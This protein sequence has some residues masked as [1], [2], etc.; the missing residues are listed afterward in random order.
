MEVK[1]LGRLMLDRRTTYPEQG[2]ATRAQTV[3]ERKPE[4][5]DPVWMYPAG[6]STI[7]TKHQII[8]RPFDS[9]NYYGPQ[10]TLTGGSWAY[11]GYRG[12]TFR[13]PP[14][15]VNERWYESWQPG[16]HPQEFEQYM[17][18]R[19]E[20]G[21]QPLGYQEQEPDVPQARDY[22]FRPTAKQTLLPEKHQ[23]KTGIHKETQPRHSGDGHHSDAHCHR[24][25]DGYDVLKETYIGKT[26]SAIGNQI[27]SSPAKKSSIKKSAK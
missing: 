3:S 21:P 9:H 22:D 5:L 4:K 8:E 1:L 10:G 18:M 26:P 19:E 20:A 2:N 7:S 11:P 13:P 27:N 14:G 23:R 15:I 24:N 6:T 25:H 16:H 12:W 17:K